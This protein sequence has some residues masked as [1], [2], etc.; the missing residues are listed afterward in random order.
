MRLLSKRRLSRL[1]LP[2]AMF[3][4]PAAHAQ[5]GD[6]H[7]PSWLDDTYGERALA[8]VAAERTRTIDRL[9]ADP[10]FDQFQ[11]EAGAIL[12]EPSRIAD[13]R[14]LGG[15]AFEFHQDESHPIGLWRRSPSSAYLAGTP[16]WETLIDFDAL[17]KSEGTTYFLGGFNCQQQRCLVRLSQN[18][19]DTAAIREF[20]LGTKTFVDGG[21]AVPPS[22]TAAWWYDENTLLVAPVLGPESVNRSGM[23]NT[24]RVWQRGTLLSAARPIFEIGDHDASL[25]ASMIRAG[26]SDRFVV[27]RHI[28]FEEREYRLMS[29]D[30]TSS[31]LPLPPLA[32]MMGVHDGQLLL[33]P[34]VDWTPDADG[35]TF[36][37]GTLVGISLQKLMTDGVVADAR[38]IY[39]P[40]GDDAL[41]GVFGDGDRLFVELLHDYFSRI[42][43][44]APNAEGTYVPRR[45]P[46]PSDR[47][48]TSY[49]MHDGK[50]LLRA[51]GPL[52][53]DE[54]ALFDPMTGAQQTLY[55]REPQ[56]HAS[57][58]VT[59]MLHTASEDGTPID[60]LVTR[61]R[62]MAFDGSNPTLVYGYGG[63]D[64]PVTP[65][66]EPV[67]GKL[68]M[69][70]GGVYVHAYLRG[71]GEHGPDWHRSAMMEGH[72]LPFSD[73]EAVLRD[74]QRRGLTSPQNV[75]IMGRSNGGLMVA[76][77][78]ER[79][80]DLMN[81]VV[82]GGP[83][84]DMLNFHQLP[85]GG[86][87]L[88]EYGDPDIAEER[89]ILREYSP[90]QNIAG[91]ETRYPVPLIITATDDDRVLP[92]HARRFA[93]QLEEYGHDRL[94]F[95][96]EQ[97]GHYWELAGGPIAGDWRL[98][99]VAR[100]VEYTYLW[101]RLGKEDQ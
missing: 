9:K 84:I 45:L 16:Q 4:I 100:A 31:P 95:E 3:S 44:L 33:R 23:P 26:G 34:E 53:P 13:V 62:T 17:S 96:D 11:Q 81:A 1:L 47:Y 79:A 88:A 71:G 19:K 22:K 67:I 85:P 59:E 25:S 89:A 58:L 73:M 36:A 35:E 98:R 29:L 93:Y 27:A 54:M 28:D 42:V 66:Y 20:D 63:Y 82:V 57:G 48:L 86:T 39:T 70:R 69:E 72:T 14:F 30:G 8:W 50:L 90:M 37:A 80:P 97:G 77:V 7:G 65:R 10:R 101:D 83:L 5:V 51:E 61:P 94:Y 68:W 40:P 6:E 87:W 60:Y 46:L 56:F 38:T 52:S 2:I 75:G 43:E 15:R 24:L 55:A 91:P 92:G 49:G 74:L 64:V 18:G 12:T 41:R 99:S 21:F 76:A 78:M 32:D